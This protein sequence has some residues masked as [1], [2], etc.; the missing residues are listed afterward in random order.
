[1][2]L[3]SFGIN[4]TP[5]HAEAIQKLIPEIPG[6]L[7]QAIAFLNHL[8]EYTRENVTALRESNAR[9]EKQNEEILRLLNGTR[10]TESQSDAGNAGS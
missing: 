5:E 9:I 4:I 10:R 6:R 2:L 3:K 8:G 7:N 1:M